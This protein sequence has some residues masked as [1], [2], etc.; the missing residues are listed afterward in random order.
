MADKNQELAS[1]SELVG[2]AGKSKRRKSRRGSKQM[3]RHNSVPLKFDLEDLTGG[4]ADLDD[5]YDDD[6]D[7]ELLIHATEEDLESEVYLMTGAG[8]D[9]ALSDDENEAEMHFKMMD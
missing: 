6:D 8:S 1:S 7:D 3:G 5:S 2:S 4:L 9:L